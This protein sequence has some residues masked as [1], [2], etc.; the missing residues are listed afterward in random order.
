[1]SKHLYAQGVR[2]IRITVVPD[3]VSVIA[4]EV[5]R[6]CEIADWVLTCG[7]IGPTHDDVTYEGIAQALGEKVTKNSQMCKAMKKI[8]GID[9]PGKMA[10][11]P[12]GSLVFQQKVSDFPVIRAGKVFI[13]P[14]IP[15]Y[16][17]SAF[18][19]IQHIITKAG[20]QFFVQDV[21]IKADELC[22][23]SVLNRVV[24]K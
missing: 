19:R 10:E 12:T 2:V 1:M 3:D 8:V 5:R 11:V 6:A 24:D 23:L 14:G 4:E 13:L 18:F 15:Q 17:E 16:C 7:G 21:R 22:F 9:N 20:V